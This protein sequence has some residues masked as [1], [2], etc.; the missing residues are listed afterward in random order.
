MA[1][2][3]GARTFFT[4]YASIKSSQI[5]DDANALGATLTAV[6]TDAIEGMMIAFEEV[7]MGFDEWNQALMDLSEPIEIAKVHFRKFF[8]EIDE[9]VTNLEDS[10][11]G[12]GAAFNQSAAD[13]IEA[14]ATM[15]Q[16]G[17]VVGGKEAQFGATQASMSLGGVGMMETQAAMKAMMQLQMQTGFM[18]EGVSDAQRQ[19]MD[20]EEQRHIVLANSIGLVDKLNE[21]ENTSGATIQGLIQAM[22]Q[23]A[24]AAALVN[25][26]MDEQIALG[27]T[28]IEQGEQSSKAGR[29]IKQM[30]ARI[31]SD[32]SQNNALLAEYNVQVRDEQGNMFT[33]MQVM[34]QLK[35]QWD[36]LNSTQQTNI[37]IGVAGAH[38][39]VRF[40]KLMEGYDRTVQIMESSTDSAGSALKEFGNFMENDTYNMHQ[41][42][43][44]IEKYN[45]EIAQKMI[46]INKTMLELDLLRIKTQMTLMTSDYTGWIAQGAAN[47]MVVASSTYEAL[48]PMLAFVL[49]TKVLMVAQ[50][51]LVATSV[52]RSTAEKY[53]SFESVRQ[54]TA[55]SNLVAEK[56]ALATISTT[57]MEMEHLI[58]VILGDQRLVHAHILNLEI[59]RMKVAMGLM[60][61]QYV[62]LDLYTSK[63]RLR[64]ADMIML[65]QFVWASTAKLKSE[66][67]E[68]DMVKASIQMRT[69][70]VRNMGAEFL[71]MDQNDMK[72][73]SAHTT[74]MAHEESAITAEN[75]RLQLLQAKLAFFDLEAVKL[76]RRNISVDMY[77]RLTTTEQRGDMQR[78]YAK[79]LLLEGIETGNM[80]KVKGIELDV[81]KTE[82]DALV[83]KGIIHRA[84]AE[85]LLTSAKKAG[86]AVTQTRMALMMQYMNVMM[87]GSMGL[88]LFAKSEN[89]AKA[90]AIMMAFALIPLMAATAAYNTTLRETAA[91]TTVI[92]GGLNLIAAAAAATVFYAAVTH[93]GWF[94]EDSDFEKEMD[95][96]EKSAKAAEAEHEAWMEQW[97]K[98]NAAMEESWADLSDT[99]VNAI[100]DMNEAMDEFDDKRM[101]VFFGGRRSAMDAAM[102]RELKQTGVENLYFAPELYVT[103]NFSGLTFEEAADRIVETIEERLKDSGAMQLTG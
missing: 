24:S 58:G 62:E 15:A 18:Y 45:Y 70:R 85:K 59:E 95:E 91:L 96:L 28:L 35:P 38:H 44:E 52:A 12:I 27:A 48:K 25:T 10:I 53:I 30:L 49:A 69:Q 1:K 37:A 21:V 50:K 81:I 26:S 47:W 34:E 13:S 20:E 83:A 68:V 8:D 7:F 19:L 4:V 90:A 66:A 55:T 72:R 22:N 86:N 17:A 54:V 57:R 29:S 40:I 101:E 3:G 33:L 42:N 56:A 9:D 78:L 71:L 39:Y 65:R 89:A 41:L 102:F 77:N 6:F 51:T 93:L 82:L 43:R 103:N 79:M 64:K 84:Q 99:S 87:L 11:I 23:Y 92:T 63:L 98:D 74:L 94:D 75:I 100:K 31:A 5:L 36:S 76:L 14:A 2:M 73:R 61:M 80:A 88:M 32:R 16:I 60:D 46:P 97:E 67:A